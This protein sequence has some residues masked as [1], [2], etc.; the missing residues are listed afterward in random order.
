MS[1]VIS[2]RNLYKTYGKGR[3]SNKVYS[4]FCL[5]IPEGNQL[6]CLTGPDG[7]GKSTLLKL[8]C[9]VLSPD[10]GTITLGGLKPDNTDLN[11]TGKIGYMSQTLGLY[12]ELSVEDNLRIFSGLKDVD[13]IQDRDYLYELLDKAGLIRFKD[14]QAKA[15]SGGMK[16]K[17]GLICALSSRPQYL[18]LDEPTVGVDP[19]SR[20]E[21]WKIIREYLQDS[22]ATCIFST[23]YLEE[24]EKS[25]LVLLFKQ[26]Q[27]IRIGNSEKLCSS[28]RGRTFTIRLCG[29]CS[30]Q[31]IARTLMLHTRH[32]DR[33]SPVLDLCPRLGKI[34][35][36]CVT[37]AQKD[38]ICSYLK[39]YMPAD[40]EAE[41]EL[42][43]R[44]SCLED[45]YIDA[46]FKEEKYKPTVNT[47]MLKDSFAAEPVIIE[48]R[49]IQKKFGSFT[50]VSHSSFKVHKGEIFGLLGPNGAGKTTTFRM[51][52]ALLVPTEGDVL[53]L[54][55][56]L[57]QATSDIRASIGYVSQK[58]TL[59]GKLTV[60]QNLKYFGQSYGLHG[61]QLN[62]RIDELLDEFYL[63]DFSNV[64]SSD[65]P[66][67]VQ[68]QLSMACAL[69]H[70]PRILFLDEATS[71][72][73]PGAR[74]N[75]WDRIS[76]LSSNGTSI[77]VTTHFMEEAE[78][79]D[80]FLIQDRG[81]IIALG[82]P[83]EICATESGRVS[84]EEAFIE[85]VK[86]FRGK[87]AS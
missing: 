7:S 29:S 24:A 31:R 36:L 81:R 6:I 39:K 26:G 57:R 65:L 79:C 45:V 37:G 70:K 3:R 52:C 84:V 68:R 27:V 78:Y 16:Q 34:Q 18:L 86:N 85:K 63:R 74:R 62:K 33:D 21:L 22:A 19:V 4:D 82:S 77:I 11:F 69:I 32:Y 59:Y 80:R 43:E 64:Q 30:F 8:L 55:Q 75:F 58:F 49:G 54:G 44:N 38:E 73:D 25:S 35:L 50:A 2:I 47:S 40:Y 1:S 66:F 71:G 13:F 12:E 76:A 17:L 83:Q 20:M 10:G 67:G 14:F 41:L 72:A 5:D 28:L 53:V 15:L 60:K 46:T 9:G 56:D 61:S 87:G 23:A 42:E 48:V 51:I